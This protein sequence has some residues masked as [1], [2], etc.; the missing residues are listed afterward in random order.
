M[1]VKPDVLRAAAVRAAQTSFGVSELPDNDDD[2]DNDDSKCLH[3]TDLIYLI[4][5][6]LLIII[7]TVIIVIIIIVFIILIIIVII[8]IILSSPSS[9]S[10]SLSLACIELKRLL[11]DGRDDYLMKIKALPH[12]EKGPRYV[13]GMCRSYGG[14]MD[15]SMIV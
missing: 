7:I 10:S 11:I 3:S 12:S 1:V 2:N 14:M 4:N 13:V 5:L 9:S 6:I 8:I 15:D